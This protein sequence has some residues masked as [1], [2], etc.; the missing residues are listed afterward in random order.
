MTLQEYNKKM[1]AF[2][3]RLNSGEDIMEEI[4]D[5]KYDYMR[6]VLKEYE[7]KADT[8]AKQECAKILDYAVNFSTSGS[9]VIFIEEKELAD[10]VDEI[11]WE[12]L[13]DYMLDGP[14]YYEENGMYVIDC[15]FAG[16]YVPE[17]E[18]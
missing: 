1:D 16:Y 4:N 14:E 13:G 5:F 3:E 8:P 2:Y 18:E 15:M 17:W 6:G 12:E 7:E 10:Q 9:V 11:I